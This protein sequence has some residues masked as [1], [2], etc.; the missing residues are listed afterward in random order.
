MYPLIIHGL[1]EYFM[2]F[3]QGDPA[4]PGAERL[5]DKRSQVLW[6]LILLQGLFL[7]V[8]FLLSVFLSHRI[9]GPL[10]KLRS[11]MDRMRTGDR[12]AREVRFRKQ[13]HFAELAESYNGLMRSFESRFD[14][15]TS[16]AGAAL[17]KLEKL[18]GQAGPEAQKSIQEAM[19]LMK[20]IKNP[21]S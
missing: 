6:Q 14:K 1:F 17:L 13:D 20:E 19:A 5:L 4:F 9:A 2:R 18:Q 3:I 8:T 21:L 10:F 12:D 7:M 15:N 11:T 16:A